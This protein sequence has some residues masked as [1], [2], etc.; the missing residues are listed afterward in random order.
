MSQYVIHGNTF[1]T[2]RPE[3]GLYVVATPIGN[4]K[5]IS[6]RALEILAGC[7]FIACEDTRH[8][9]R[10]LTHYGIKAKTLAYHEHN[11]DRQAKTLIEHIEQ[12]KAL[13]LVSDA[14]TPLLSDPGQRLVTELVRRDL[15]VFPI[16]GASAPL[17]AL[18]KS[19]FMSV[20]FTFVGFLPHKSGPRKTML[21]RFSDHKATLIFFEAPTR[22]DASLAD[23]AKIFGD[24]RQAAILREL[25]KLHEERITGP[26]K[27][28]TN[29]FADKK[30]K[31][32][33]V[34]VIEGASETP[35]AFDLDQLLASLLA[36][37]SLSRAVGEAAKIT[38]RPKR[39]IYARALELD[40]LSNGH[41]L[42]GK[43][44]GE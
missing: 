23:M 22:L 40:K 1:S 14:G 32:E 4:L 33:I 24:D 43:R 20:P 17:A 36:E 25:T 10:L 19:G 27:T 3:P 37:H 7:D 16:P 29:D 34:I 31:G 42:K 39:K 6:I 44:D 11:A 8:S 38:N 2:T 15:P 28:L 12:G 41:T 13:A 21:E 26:L 5:D 35:D 9:A 30:V 18:V